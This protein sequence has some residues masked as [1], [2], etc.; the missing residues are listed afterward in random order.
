MFIDDLVIMS[1]TLSKVLT[2]DLSLASCSLRFVGL[3][4]LLT[5]DYN[6]IVVP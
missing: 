6:I 5:G 3:S 4:K 2:G 1:V